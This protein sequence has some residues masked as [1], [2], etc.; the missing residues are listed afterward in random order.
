MTE[1][2]FAR[3]SQ[4]TRGGRRS[5]LAVLLVLVAVLAVL[6]LLAVLI[7][8]PG[9]LSGI[10]REGAR[11]EGIGVVEV[12]GV[13][14]SSDAVVKELVRFGRDNRVRAILLRIDSPGGG[15]AA[16]QEIYREVMRTRE[17]KKVVASMGGVAASGGLYVAAAADRV[18]ADPGTLTG[19]ISVIMNLANYEELFRKIGLRSIT[20]KSGEFKD[21]GSPTRPMTDR[22]KEILQK[23]VQDMHEQFVQAVA[24]GRGLPVEKVA[25]LADGRVFTGQEAWRLG[26]VDELGNFEDAVALA[27]E[28]A[29]I[30]G[31][32]NLIYPRRTRFNMWD[33]LLGRN[34]ARQM[35]DWLAHPLRIQYLYAPGL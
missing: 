26:L 29:G 30:K 6:V 23:L 17:R 10:G 35:T 1:E 2:T 34:Q 28:L 14:L 32:P 8:S 9:F 27:A 5:C 7:G 16:S 25:A 21:I 11:G 18:V 24:Q 31:R 3:R 12:E 13:I 4:P 15:V 33:L 22:E 20:I 19:S